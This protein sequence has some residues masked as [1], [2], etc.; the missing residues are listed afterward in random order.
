MALTVLGV[1]VES[2]KEKGEVGF[3]LEEHLAVNCEGADVENGVW[4]KVDR[5]QLVIS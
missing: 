4:G 2:F 1:A 3:D 5:R